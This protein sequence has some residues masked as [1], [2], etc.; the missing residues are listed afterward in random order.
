MSH[1]QES[2]ATE[3]MPPGTTT[4]FTDKRIPSYVFDQLKF[5]VD[6]VRKMVRRNLA[7]ELL[8]RL[9]DAGCFEFEERDELV[10]NEDLSS[11]R[12][13]VFSAKIEIVMPQ[14]ELVE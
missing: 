11:Y 1:R 6:C 8:T 7:S 2:R 13:I 12:N 14:K 5:S 9:I 3:P 4:L 10:I